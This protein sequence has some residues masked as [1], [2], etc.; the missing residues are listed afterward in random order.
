MATAGQIQYRMGLAKKKL[1][2]FV[3]ELAA[4]KKKIKGLEAQ[5][6]K[7]KAAKKV[8][9][10]AKKKAKARRKAGQEEEDKAN[11]FRFCKK[12]TRGHPWRSGALLSFSSPL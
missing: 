12:V 1:A 6:K 4:T 8:K 11:L 7:A 10:K 2:K 3:K 9:P 5:H